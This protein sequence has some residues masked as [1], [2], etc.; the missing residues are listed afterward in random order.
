MNQT[1]S[2][3][4]LFIALLGS[5]ALTG[6]SN[7][8]QK[9]QGNMLLPGW[10]LSPSV[11]DGLADTAC[12]TWSG[13]MAID[14]DEATAISRNRLALQ[15]EVR[16]AN[17]TKT[18]ASKT[19]ANGG[20]NVGTTFESNAR[21]I[22]EATLKGSKAVKTDLFEIDNKKQLCVMVSLEAQ[23]LES[24]ANQIIG[25]S[26]AR[27]SNE[28]KAVLKEQFKAGAGQRALLEATGV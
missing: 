22:S 26:G 1:L 4:A 15:I 8:D 28:D 2:Q 17:M 3:R 10:V 16:A 5:L 11:E 13:N 12:V 19:Q 9:P 27:L 20:T 7:N 21:Q 23:Q 24:I 14:R 18:Y 25:Q 6:C